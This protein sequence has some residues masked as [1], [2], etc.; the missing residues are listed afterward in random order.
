MSASKQIV[1]AAGEGERRW[2]YGGGLHTWKATSEDSNGAFFVLEDELARGKSTPLHTHPQDEI[3]FV[4]EGELLCYGDG[5]EKRVGPGT[6]I[7]T[8][9]GVP[10]AFT[11][12][13]ERARIFFVQTPGG[14]DAFY[15]KASE[16]AGAE[17]GPVDFRKLGEVAKA[18]GATE[19][20]GPPPFKR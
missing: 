7:I 10:H 20:L 18:T 19:I 3:V 9:R 1:K 11:V 4:I 14:G 12:L 8:P 16:P 2:F 5:V 6:T 13:S 15:R 17:A